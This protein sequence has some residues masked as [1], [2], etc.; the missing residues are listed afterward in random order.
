MKHLL[1]C[2]KVPAD[3][4]NTMLKVTKNKNVVNKSDNSSESEHSSSDLE[5]VSETQP[6]P[7]T[8]SSNKITPFFDKISEEDQIKLNRTLAN[9]IFVS[10]SPLS[11]TSNP[12]WKDVFTLYNETIFQNTFST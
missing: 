9:A 3:V 5:V 2:I 12:V 6:G 4:K 11:L 8:I 7:K 1:K 10:G